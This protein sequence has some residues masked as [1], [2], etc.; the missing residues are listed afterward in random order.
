MAS[1]TVLRTDPLRNFK[2]R[3]QIIPKQSGNLQTT[4]NQIGEL[5]FAQVSGISVTNEI[6]SYREGGMNTHPHK[7]VAQSDFAPVSFARGAFSGQG[8]LF[9]WQKFLHAWLDGGVG[10]EAGLAKGDG[11]YR[12]DILV[13]VY[14]HPHTASEVEGQSG[15]KYQWDGSEMMGAIVPGKVKFQFK[16]YN[17]WPGAYALTDLNAGDNGILIQSMT[18]HHEGFY[19]DWNGTEDLATK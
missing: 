7:M 9:Q 13:K 8:Q 11:D 3:V 5:G 16:L 17:A 4:L 19:I 10:G 15:L 1:A 6:I 12:C 18:V 14:D 2:F